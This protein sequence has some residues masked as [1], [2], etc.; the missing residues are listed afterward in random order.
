M[1][2]GALAFA[3]LL[4]GLTVGRVP[5]EVLATA[6]VAQVRVLLDGAPVAAAVAPPWR[7]DVDFGAAPTPHR[8]EAIGL[9]SAGAEVARAVQWVNLPRPSAELDLVL[10]R[11]A[12]GRP[13]AARLVWT[14]ALAH[15]PSAVR[16]ELDGESVPLAGPARVALPPGT[17]TGSHFL[18]VEAEFPGGA[19]AARE[20]AFGGAFVAGGESALTAIPVETAGGD[21]PVAGAVAARLASGEPLYTAALEKGSAR[22]VVVLDAG[23]IAPLEKAA[24]VRRE[25]G[26]PKLWGGLASRCRWLG[27]EL[28]TGDDEVFVVDPGPQEI[29]RDGIASWL[30]TVRGRARTR[31]ADLV[32]VLMRSELDELSEGRRALS[33]AVANAGLV[34]A[35]GG[36]RRAVVLI[37]GEPGVDGGYLGVE[38]ARAFLRELDVPLRV[39]SPL[40]GAA[41]DGGRAWGA[42]RDV[43]TCR[44]LGQANREVLDTL[45]RQ[46][47]VWV[48]GRHLPRDVV[49]VSPP[50]ARAR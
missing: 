27:S 50:L 10:E 41:A 49:V 18:R 43:S 33:N 14:T 40:A 39:W 17:G 34:A 12:R 21:A 1:E 29:V 36:R 28:S 16:A 15:P 32:G 13:A 20:L 5:V 46:R 9:D 31:A 4:I 6:P 35:A 2:Q 8:L 48:E 3:T 24:G 19:V 38:D 11:D 26:R 25:R 47:I 23:A 45:E 42:V 44:L 22:I 30:F 7:V 37:L